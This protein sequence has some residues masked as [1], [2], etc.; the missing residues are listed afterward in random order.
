MVTDYNPDKIIYLKFDTSSLSGKEI[1]SV[2][3]N[4]VLSSST[5]KST[6]QYIKL[7]KD[8]TW[9]ESSINYGNRPELGV[10]VGSFHG[11]SLRKTISESLSFTSANLSSKYLSLAIDT[12][13]TKSLTINSSESSTPPTLVVT[14]R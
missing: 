4:V 2:K 8:Q 12:K 13:S 6:T 1:L 5:S 7:V 9:D 11:G 10:V 14:Y 3:L